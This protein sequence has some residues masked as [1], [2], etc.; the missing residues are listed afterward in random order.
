MLKENAKGFNY[1]WR[2]YN[3]QMHYEPR[4][5]CDLIE[6]QAS[7]IPRGR[8]RTGACNTSVL[9]G[10][11]ACPAPTVACPAPAATSSCG[12]PW[13]GYYENACKMAKGERDETVVHFSGNETVENRGSLYQPKDG[14][15][16]NCSLEAYENGLDCCADGWVPSRTTGRCLKN[17]EQEHNEHPDYEGIYVNNA[18]LHP[19]IDNEI[20][21]LNAKREAA[22]LANRTFK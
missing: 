16:S 17:W 3:G 6:L 15:Y 8:R 10:T 12:S 18:L 1:V 5:E 7:K 20:K 2:N 9:G 13:A 11:S 4:E 14:L 22:G 21:D 19:H